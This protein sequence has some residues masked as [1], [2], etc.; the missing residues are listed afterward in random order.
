MRR[1]WS[2]KALKKYIDQYAPEYGEP[3]AIRAYSSQL[4]G[5]NPE[6][7]LHGGGNTSVKAPF[8]T[9]LGE[10]IPAVYVKGSGWDMATTGPEGFVPLN[11][12]KLLALRNLR[13]LDDDAMF[14]QFKLAMLR[15]LSFN[16][17]IEALSHAWVGKTYVDHTHANAIL[18]LTNRVD[19]ESITRDALGE[20]VLIRPYI[21]PGFLLSKDIADALKAAPR[22]RGVVLMHHGLF[23][24][25]DDPRVSYESHI[26]LVEKAK[27]YIREK[28]SRSFFDFEP[29]EN[30]DPALPEVIPFVR[31]M[32][33]EKTGEADRP[34]KTV[35]LKVMHDGEIMRILSH[36]RLR[37]FVEG[38]VLTADFLIRTK[39]WMAWVESPDLHDL[40]RLRKQIKETVQN[41]VER[42]TSYYEKGVRYTKRSFPMF[43]PRPRILVVPNLGVFCSG[44]DPDQA[45]MTADLARA[46]LKVKMD[47]AATGGRH[48]GIEEGKLFEMEYWGPQL[49][50]L[51]D[52][53]GALS[54]KVAVV[55]GAAGAIGSA[56]CRRLLEEDC[57]VV[58][59]DLPGERLETLTEE[60]S[61][62][63]GAHFFGQAMDVTDET[64]VREAFKA[65]SLQFG[66]ADI[67]IPNAGIALVKPLDELELEDF[68]R[69]HR[70]NVEGMLLFL[71]WGVKLLK[72]QKTGG[73]IIFIST[74]NVPSPGASFGAYSATK[75]AAHQLARVASLE[76]APFDIRV[77]NLAPD[78]VF[79]GGQRRSGLW[80]V[81]GP[82]RMKARGLDEKG[83]EDYYRNRNLL[84]IQVR[85]DHVANGVIFF[86]TRQTPTTG[87]TLPIDGGLPDATPR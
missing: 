37:E 8:T 20:E 4:L 87:A 31:G 55:T 44:I 50:K 63:F 48:Q 18:T 2:N 79:R 9:I 33:S 16:P 70:V 13:R 64:S 39:P 29:V 84:K 47:I 5:R 40:D 51:S 78:A 28:A 85:A 27:S 57:V 41:F 67:L 46:T 76:L 10:T 80:E 61:R 24:F 14:E 38:P 42:Y 83:L 71:R 72:N 56:I 75:A 43:N 6:L 30:P 36:P 68:R 60:L 86:A 25:D 45:A 49:A 26:E 73:D 52:K 77:N 15:P 22:A 17:S 54:G 32:L 53:S 66:G 23:T 35:I 3:L 58:G 21:H 69:V 12:E 81:C 65:V 74:K 34:F 11:L 82:E 59:T 1:H 19:G 7:V 62:D